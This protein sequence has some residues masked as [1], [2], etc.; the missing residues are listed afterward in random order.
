MHDKRLFLLDAMAL[1]YRAHFVFISN[2]RITSVG[3][4][5]S[6]VFGFTLTL[7]ELLE[8][9]KPSHIGVAF[10]STTITHRE[11]KFADYKA[12]REPP[13]EDLIKAIPY[14]QQLLRGFGIPVL[15]V[16][17]YEA[18]DVMGTL[19]VKAAKKGYQVYLMTPDKDFAQLV[20][21]KI[22]LYRPGLAGKPHEVLGV[23]GVMEKYGVHP[24]RVTDLLGLKGDA[25]DNI[26][27]IPRIGDKT[28]VQLLQQFGTLEEVIARVGEITKPALRASIIENADMGRFSKELATI[29]TDVP[30]AFDE[31]A[32][33]LTPP[34]KPALEELFRELEFRSIAKRVFGE[35]PTETDKPA[36]KKKKTASDQAT[37]DFGD[38]DDTTAPDADAEAAER[39]AT[40]YNTAAT[41]PHTYVIADTSAIR[42]E[43]VKAVTAN[44]AFCF[45]TETT[46]LES[47]T[48]E[49]VGLSIAITPHEAW[50]VPFPPSFEEA[51]KV[52]HEFV[53]IFTDAR[54]RKIG[55]NMKYDLAILRRYGLEV[56]GELYD[57]M[58]AHY[59]IRSDGKH[60][61]DAMSRAYLHYDPIS[62]ET[63]IGKKG[64]NQLNT[65][66]VAVEK[67]AEYAAEDADVT[68]QLHH[69]LD[70]QLD[71]ED[72]RKL[73]ESVEMPLM[74]VLLD[75]EWEGVRIDVDFLQSYSNELEK[76]L[77]VLEHQIY[78]LAGNEFN[79]NSPKQLGEVLFGKL[80]LGGKP[81]LT[82][83]GQYATDEETLTYLASEHEVPAKVLEFRGLTKLKGTYVDAL[84]LLVNPRTGRVHTSFNQ[85]VAV[86]GRLSSNNPNLQNIPIR[87]DRGREVRKAFIP[88]DDKHTLLSADYSQIELRL[89]AH[90]SGDEAMRKAF[91]SGEDIHTST[92]ARVFGVA[93]Q[94][95]D[96]DMR[97]KAKMVNFGIIY[98]I[99]PFGLAQRLG[100]DRTEAKR[101]IDAYFAQYPDVSRFMK[102]C[103][104]NARMRGYAQ[105]LMG[106]RHYLPNLT[107]RNATVRGFA[108][109][110]AINTPLQGTAA[111]LIKL[112]MIQLHKRMR[113]EGFAGKMILQVHDELLFDVPKNEVEKL[114]PVV[115][116]CMQTAMKL[117]VPLEVSTGVGANWLDAH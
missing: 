29:H 12:H 31:E 2:P 65:R 54:I 55:Q 89:M 94:E 44:K 107:S 33:H 53:P 21:D 6:A 93:L 59:C 43:I 90:L 72:T 11:Q 40:P 3:L 110:N 16:D 7:L 64:K 30:I 45:D 52:V 79:I 42:K 95:V 50:Y 1:I 82:A 78:K 101:I 92:A 14:V 75:M 20:N 49:I 71:K 87:T 57:T 113:E 81:K 76:E 115:Q 34:D 51:K 103:V 91:A 60:G 83:T 19:A 73:F 97:R 112:A 86:T 114:R 109:R 18:D 117:A 4:N 23:E 25:S 80:K 100:I 70:P 68:L 13:P 62:I 10:E 105:T 22:L 36:V 77:H 38:G 61:M 39:I 96:F 67:L 8:K 111:E 35:S 41:V 84:P 9:E 5:T 46:S 63:L 15:Q 106:R 98:G 56:A 32:L 47:L 85:S 74:P 37:L 28:A 27:G 17:G 99:T 104:E 58:L 88:R 102:D 24:D 66:Q 116:A 108:E 26:P 69:K 48:A